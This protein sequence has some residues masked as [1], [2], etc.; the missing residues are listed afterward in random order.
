MPKPSEP[1]ARKIEFTHAKVKAIR[2]PPP[3]ILIEDGREIEKTAQVDYWD[4]KEGFTGFG[5]RVSSIIQTPKGPRGGSK[6]WQLVYR[7]NGRY[8]RFKLGKFP[9]LPLADARA[10]AGRALREIEL[11]DDPAAHKYEARRVIRET[12]TFAELTLAFFDDHGSKKKSARWIERIIKKEL[13]PR[14]GKRLALNIERGEVRAMHKTISERAPIMANRVLEVMKSIYSWALTQE[15]HSSIKI[16]P[17]TGVKKNP[18]RKDKR[19]LNPNEIGAVWSAMD[20]LEPQWRAFFQLC[21]LTGQRPGE[22]LRMRKADLDLDA[23]W[24][25]MPEG[26]AKNGIA[27][28]VPLSGLA[29]EAIEEALSESDDPDYVFP[30]RGGGKPDPANLSWKKSARAMLEKSGIPHF[31]CDDFRATAIT[32][33]SSEPLSF[34][35]VT[36][37]KVANHANQAITDRYVRHGYDAEKR[38][39]LEAWADRISEIVGLAPMPS[40]VEQLRVR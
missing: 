19:F 10:A 11:G 17:A 39:A 35:E 30:R 16:N 24:W 22:I 4:A 12:P 13:V 33:L 2:P 5:L 9:Q 7:A 37:A 20:E 36:V 27:H 38:R 26:Y 14:F 21:L 1:D 31:T 28:S 18:E 25:V 6:T 23:A 32:G 15:F 8:R 40:N 29:L 3:K 34:P